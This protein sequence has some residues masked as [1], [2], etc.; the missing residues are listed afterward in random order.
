MRCNHP[1]VA[2]SR[3]VVVGRWLVG[4]AALALLAI[5]GGP[6]S[7]KASEKPGQPVPIRAVADTFLADK[8]IRVERFEPAAL[9]SAR[10]LLRPHRQHPGKPEGHR[11]VV[12]TLF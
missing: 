2:L 1:V 8:L 9:G 10:A 4:L 7:G 3:A 5:L 11:G 6:N 12:P